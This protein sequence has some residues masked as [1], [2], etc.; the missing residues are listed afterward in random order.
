[1]H[2]NSLVSMEKINLRQQL[3]QTN[4]KMNLSLPLALPMS[5]AKP[6]VFITDVSFLAK[7]YQYAELYRLIVGLSNWVNNARS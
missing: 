3:Q 4:A 7:S 6:E 1:V 5:N 2:V